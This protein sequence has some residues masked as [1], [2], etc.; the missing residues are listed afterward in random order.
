MANVGKGP[1]DLGRVPG[2]PQYIGPTGP[3]APTS[4]GDDN[5]VVVAERFVSHDRRIDDLN[6]KVN[7]FITV[8][9]AIILALAGIQVT[10]I[11]NNANSINS[12]IDRLESL[13]IQDGKDLSTLQA[14]YQN[15]VKEIDNIRL[16]RQP[17][18]HQRVKQ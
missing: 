4:Y 13:V 15:I 1:I 16:E 2:H 6:A 7:I 18:I 12:K 9:I 10:I 8:T 17:A 14:N 11:L 3:P 5:D